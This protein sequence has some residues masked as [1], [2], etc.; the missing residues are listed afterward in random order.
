MM[1][2][3]SR[4]NEETMQPHLTDPQVIRATGMDGATLREVDYPDGFEMAPHDHRFDCLVFVMSG[5]L[6]GTMG[7]M[8]LQAP[9]GS[10]FYVPMGARHTN[11]FHGSV[12][13]FDIVLS[14]HHRENF[15]GYIQ[16]ITGFKTWE[17]TAP[18][19][20]ASRMISETRS[21]DSASSLI[22]SGLLLE[23]IGEASRATKETR[24]T[25]P[26]WLAKAIDYAQANL[27]RP[28]SIEEIGREIGVHPAHLSRV[29]RKQYGCTIG[30]YVRG[31]RLERASR[32]IRD[33]EIPLSEVAFDAG[34]TD[35]SHFSRSFKARMGMTPTRYRALN[36]AQRLDKSTSA[37]G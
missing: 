5:V 2:V 23:L 6:T 21:S 25:P 11:Q 9:P 28:F 4:Q 27:S 22:L 15:G 26:P 34:F 37:L 19:M 24:T 1:G 32:L 20:I 13:T 35:Q 8:D 30:E 7:A 31:L 17:N 33:A 29:F 16:P 36:T 14:P 12:R 10:L 3:P 18:T